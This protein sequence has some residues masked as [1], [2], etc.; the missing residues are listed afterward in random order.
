[1]NLKDILFKTIS[2][3]NVLPLLS[4]TKYVYFMARLWILLALEQKQE[5]PFSRTVTQFGVKTIL[6]L[7]LKTIDAIFARVKNPTRNYFN[8]TLRF[9]FFF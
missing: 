2:T 7:K 9:F 3:R 5:F 8:A 4:S 6:P 1:M